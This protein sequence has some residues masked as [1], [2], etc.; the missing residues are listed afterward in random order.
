MENSSQ[1]RAKNDRDKLIGLGE[2]SSRKSYYPLLKKK[3]AQLEEYSLELKRSNEELERFAYV[4][5]HDL[6]EPLRMISSF[7]SLLENR[8]GENL[9]E[10]GKKYIGFAVEG[11][12]RMREMIDAI[13]KY[14]RIDRSEVVFREVS[15]EKILDE[16][17]QLLSVSIQ[18]SNASITNDN[19][20]NLYGDYNQILSLFQNI[21]I[22]GIKFRRKDTPPVIHISSKDTEE[23][24]EISF[25]DNGIGIREDF[26]ER[27]FH[28]FQRLHTHREYE[29][30]GMGLTLCKKIAI[31][32]GGDIRVQSD[33]NKGS[34][35]FVTIAKPQQP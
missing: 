20:P 32:H 22:N 24:W 33:T 34:I 7:L 19:L 31:R 17:K 26:Y 15:T 11:A 29:G 12:S 9:D 3:I 1:S 2:K 27:I 18:E 21:I 8:Y 28:I 13:L 16:V 5:S 10:E 35:F 14:S 4:A 23:M 6:K 25:E 30:I